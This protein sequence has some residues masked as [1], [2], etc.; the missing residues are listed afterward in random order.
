MKKIAALS[1]LVS[2]ISFA[3][4]RAIPYIDQDGLECAFTW[5]EN[6]GYSQLYFYQSSSEA[7]VAGPYQLN[8]AP[9]G[10]AG[11]YQFAPYLDQDGLECVLAW[12]STTGSS[13]LFFY[14]SDSET[15]V[16]APYQLPSS[17]TG[18]AGKFHMVPYLDQDGLECVLVTNIL[19]GT[20]KLYFYSSDAEDFIESPYQ[21]PTR[22]TGDI[23]EYYCIPY[24][25]QDGLECVLTYNS[26]TGKSV[27]YYYSSDAEDF[28]ESP[29]QL[30]QISSGGTG[31]IHMRP[32]LDQDG[33]EC[34]ITYNTSGASTLYF[35]SSDSEDFIEAPYQLPAAPA[36][37]GKLGGKYMITPYLDQ[38]GLECMLACNMVTGK[39]VLYFYSSDSQSFV[40][41]PY[42]L[43]MLR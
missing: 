39:T 33:L 37:E 9:T 28:T 42:Q 3:Q 15:F 43:P 23:G 25:D 18:D 36:G 6:T 31:E 26:K 40:E 11:V 20:S 21:L 24:L 38:D 27:L 30:D 22:P 16:E 2:Q 10:D 34:V 35:Y 19:T 32:Y 7:F 13:R 14:S 5:N 4:Y 8:T 17:P 12:N 41:S 1:L 29:Y